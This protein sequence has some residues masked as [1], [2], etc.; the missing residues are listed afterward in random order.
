MA[1]STYAGC[2][3]V[4][5]VRRNEVY[6]LLCMTMASCVVY[7]CV[8]N[9][10]I[11]IYSYILHSNLAPMNAAMF[12]FIHI[13]MYVCMCHTIICM[14]VCMYVCGTSCVHGVCGIPM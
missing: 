9:V 2:G 1:A 6:N 5:H 3:C 12:V 7:L 11:Y 14:L 10:Y 8:C 13:R 4:W